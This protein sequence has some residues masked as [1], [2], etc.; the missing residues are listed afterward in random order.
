MD[1]YER[2]IEHYADKS[3][4]ELNELLDQARA[5]MHKADAIYQRSRLRSDKDA[6]ETASIRFYNLQ[7]VI[8]NRGESNGANKISN[9]T[10]EMAKA[11]GAKSA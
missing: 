3:V 2:I 9:T 8:R 10:T 11:A 5:A 6:I 7:V 1:Y 4:S